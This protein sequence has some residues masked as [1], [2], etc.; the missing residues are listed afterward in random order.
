MCSCVNKSIFL[1]CYY[2]KGKADNEKKNKNNSNI[3]NNN[4]NK[5]GSFFHSRVKAW[6]RSFK[7]I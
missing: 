2:L 4:S 1:S 6:K 5:K 7:C 3:I